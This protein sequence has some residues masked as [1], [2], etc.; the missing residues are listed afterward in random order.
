MKLYSI[1]IIK[2]ILI[3]ISSS[4]K[5]DFDINAP[6]NDVPVIFG[7]LDQSIDTQ[8]VKINKTYQGEGDNTIY[9]SINDSILFP[10]VSAIV[11]EE[12][13][14]AITNSYNLEEKWIKNIQQ[15]LFNT[16]SQKIYYF[17]PNGGLNT[18]A[19]Y[20]LKINIDGGRKIVTSQT[21]LVSPF[22]FTS[23]FK[24]IVHSGVNF[25]STQGYSKLPMRWTSAKGAS[26]YEA[27][28][29]FYYEEHN[30]NGIEEKSI[31]W[32]LGVSTSSTSSG[33]EEMLKEIQG[34]GFY[35]TIAARLKNQPNE[36]N[37]SKRVAKRI[38]F[39]VVAAGEDFG[40]Y[41]GVNEPSNSIVSERPNFTN[42]NGGL[43]IFSS[44]TNLVIKEYLQGS[45]FVL[46]YNSQQEL[47][48]GQYTGYLKFQP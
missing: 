34:D 12:I 41:I 48:N 22:D 30:Q 14:G 10:N 19:K 45:P 2:I 44:R 26:K 38:E 37:I 35:K 7:L 42:I 20:K 43:G 25:K 5:T 9:A 23:T 32:Q 21:E 47:E 4:C 29:V 33:G 16:D 8:Y 15:G 36:A 18:A 6:Y 31:R 40:T 13:N 46:G 27:G 28:L 3:A 39:F 11:D 1:I 24:I 17:V